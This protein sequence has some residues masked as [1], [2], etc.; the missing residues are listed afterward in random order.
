[1][2]P[3]LKSRESQVDRFQSLIMFG[4]EPSDF[5]SRVG[6]KLCA[7]YDSSSWVESPREYRQLKEK[8]CMHERSAG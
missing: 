4:M 2:M 6:E 3:G 5:P 8:T 1:M 7:C